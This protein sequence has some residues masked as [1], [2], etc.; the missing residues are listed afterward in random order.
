MKIV[1]DSITQLPA[2]TAQYPDVEITT[3]M[4]LPFEGASHGRHTDVIFLSSSRVMLQ[5]V[6]DIRF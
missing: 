6:N 2:Y 4:K 3:V 1:G 5:A